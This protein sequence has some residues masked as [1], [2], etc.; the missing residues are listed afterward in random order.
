MLTEL[1]SIVNS[2]SILLLIGLLF[3]YGKTLRKV[4]SKFTIGLMV[5]ASLFLVEKLVWLYFC[6]TKMDGYES[7][8]GP[9]LLPISV[10]QA[11]AFAV[12]LIITWE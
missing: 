8:M 5:F 11:I 7:V 2:I 10:L 1:V 9:Y 12:L 3:I 4:R 6:L